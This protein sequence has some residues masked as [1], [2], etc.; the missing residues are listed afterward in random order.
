MKTILTALVVTLLS[1]GAANA[2]DSFRCNNRIIDVGASLAYVMSVCGEPAVHSSHA[3]PV[4]SRNFRG[5]SFISGF[6]S[7]DQLIYYRGWGRFPVE[8]DF[9]AGTLRQIHYLPHRQ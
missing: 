2:V 9:D 7:S 4:R 5:F 1:C 6:S 8:L 3:V